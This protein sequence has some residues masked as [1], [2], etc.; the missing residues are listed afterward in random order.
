MYSGYLSAIM[1]VTFV[2][3]VVIFLL[4][5]ASL[6]NIFEQILL[7]ACMGI[8]YDY[9]SGS[10]GYKNLGFGAFVA[11][12]A[13]V[14]VFGSNAG[15]ALPL[16]VLLAGVLSSAVSL[17]IS[18]PFLRVKGAY[19][20][21]ASLT[22]VLLLEVADTNLYSFT[23]G[24]GGV[25][26]LYSNAILHSGLY[27]GL[28]ALTL[29]CLYFHLF[30][31]R[32]LLGLAM[33]SIKED[34]TVAQSFGVNSFRVKQTAMA[35]SA[36]FGGLTGALFAIYLGFINVSNVLGIGIAMYPVIASLIGG[37]GIF[38][39]PMIGGLILVFANIGLPVIMY[40]LN[41]FLSAGP[42]IVT[43]VILLI[44]GLFLPGGILRVRYFR[45]FSEQKVD[46]F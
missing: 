45:K 29:F 12:G 5:V 41:S 32:S 21:I 17:A 35:I 22:L 28:V 16:S 36:F 46:P 25:R 15:L 39:G 31:S 40:S 2:L 27:F 42:L 43:G 44:V 9:F 30:L 37:A 18:Y 23:G 11:L 10:T 20:A 33:K 4:D 13:Y 24:T 19:F 6:V 7:I 14:L 8:S 3:S 1:I 38:L 34:E 26:L